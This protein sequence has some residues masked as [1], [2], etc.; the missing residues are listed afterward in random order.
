MFR[1]LFHFIVR[2][3]YF[4]GTCL[5]AGALQYIQHHATTQQTQFKKPQ[6]A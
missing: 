1:Q 2:I 3:V 6:Y 4:A 5:L